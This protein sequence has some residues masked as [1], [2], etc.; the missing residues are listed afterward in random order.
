MHKIPA[1]HANKINLVAHSNRAELQ[2]LPWCLLSFPALL[3]QHPA[4]EEW[5][6]VWTGLTHSADITSHFSMPKMLLVKIPC[7]NIGQAPNSKADDSFSVFH[8]S[9]LSFLRQS[10]VCKLFSSSL[11]CLLINV[12]SQPLF[13][14]FSIT[15]T[16]AIIFFLGFWPWLCANSSQSGFS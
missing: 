2:T 10:S 9:H 12:P 8:P 4:E 7:E 13:P 6:Q 15:K 16:T 11:S 1:R 3:L 14:Q 5:S